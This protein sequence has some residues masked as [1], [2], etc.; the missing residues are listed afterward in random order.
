MTSIRSTSEE[1]T[2]AAGRSCAGSLRPG[3]VVALFGTLGSGKTRFITGICEALGVQIHATSP[4]FTL[5]NEYPA[6]FGTVVHID[7]YRIGS[8]QELAELGVE[9][10]FTDRCICLIEWAEVAQD[11]LPRKHV[12]VRMAHGSVDTERRITIRKVPGGGS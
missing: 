2:V 7:L 3:D 6:P 11:I 5:I 4:T 10:Y 8:K 1:E 12:E 9:D